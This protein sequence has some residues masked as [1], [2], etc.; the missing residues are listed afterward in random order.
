MIW[1]VF[2]LFFC[3]ASVVMVKGQT[4]DGNAVYSFLG[5]PFHAQTAAMGGR[6]ISQMTSTAGIVSENPALL[7]PHHHKNVFSNFTFLAPGITGLQGGAAWHQE[8]MA[9]TFALGV[10][11]LQYGEEPLTDPSGNV[12]GD[13]R[14]FDQAISLSASRKYG[15]NWYYGGTFKV[16]LSAY[17][18]W[19]SMGMAMD[20]GVNYHQQD[21]GFQWGFSVKNMGRQLTQFA[22]Q[23]EDLPFDMVLGVS[24]KLDK[25]PFGI[26][27]TAQRLHD[28]DLLYS[29]T[30]YNLE[31]FGVSGR[32]GWGKQLLS[33]LVL[34]TQVFVG[35]KITLNGGINLLKR[36]ELAVRN[37][38][39]GMAGFSYGISLR[40]KKLD[41]QFARFHNLRAF[42]QQQIAVSFDF[43]TS[44]Q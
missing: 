18:P 3:V 13:F 14:A 24:K 28:F 34:G 17:G 15:E 29:D 12:L 19:R 6:N 16:I 40:H 37:V 38:A 32:P 23:A 26:S 42:A 20:M 25:A 7:R 4:L 1:R 8:K 30:A 33:H 39:S 35:E 11:H 9:T 27:L 36:N 44:A 31:N 21:A 5:L 41:F 22:G 43:G 2:K 10:T